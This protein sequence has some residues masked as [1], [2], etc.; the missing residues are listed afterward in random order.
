MKRPRYFE[1]IF[2]ILNIPH[3]SLS[4]SHPRYVGTAWWCGHRMLHKLLD[5]YYIAATFHQEMGRAAPIR[6]MGNIGRNLENQESPE[7][8]L[9]VIDIDLL[10]ENLFIPISVLFFLF[11][12]S[13]KAIHQEI[14]M[15]R[16]NFM[17][18]KGFEPLNSCENRS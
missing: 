2:I 18:G 14:A 8:V 13:D 10:A 4:W 11:Y 17:R 1:I 6:K 16:P 7:D 12:I 3:T 15:L 5:R 9:R